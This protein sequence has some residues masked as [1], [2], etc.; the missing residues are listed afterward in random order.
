[1]PLY[2]YRCGD[3]GVFEAWRSLSEL[4]LPFHCPTCNLPGKRIFSPPAV[5]CGSFR[6]KQEIREPQLIKRDLEPKQQRV[7][8][9][10]GGRPWMISH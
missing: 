4:D 6:L 9:H 1:M 3:C 2:E 10:A 5:L 7:K 8:N